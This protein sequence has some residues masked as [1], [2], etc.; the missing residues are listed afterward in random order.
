MCVHAHPESVLPN[1]L[2]EIG[3]DMDKM[4][5]YIDRLFSLNSSSHSKLLRGGDLRPMMEASL[6]ALL[7]YFNERVLT[8]E[9]RLVIIRMINTHKECFGSVTDPKV[10]L[11]SWGSQIQSNFVNQNL[12]LRARTADTSSVQVI[13]AVSNMG[14]SI[15][16]LINQVNKLQTSFEVPVLIRACVRACL[17]ACVRAVLIRS[18][19]HNCT[20]ARTHA[21]TRTHTNTHTHSRHS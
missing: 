17:R 5:D 1:Y 9:M 11:T 4:Q 14:K 18:L 19:A 3:V 20:H 15:S 10:T 8:G 7:M 6:A 12:H 21:R 2:Q 16:L 13:E